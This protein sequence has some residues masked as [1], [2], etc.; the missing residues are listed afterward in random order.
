MANQG[1]GITYNADELTGQAQARKD[2]FLNQC[3]RGRLPIQ[4]PRQFLYCA[5]FQLPSADWG[6]SEEHSPWSS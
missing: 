2:D 4:Y 1:H 3:D 5:S 6:A